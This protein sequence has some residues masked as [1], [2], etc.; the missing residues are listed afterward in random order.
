MASRGEIRE[1]V[2]GPAYYPDGTYANT[3]QKGVDLTVGVRF[4]TPTEVFTPTRTGGYWTTIQPGTGGLWIQVKSLEPVRTDASGQPD[5][6]ELKGRL[7]KNIDLALKKF[8]SQLTHPEAK[9]RWS[10]NGERYKQPLSNP[11]S[12]EVHLELP[13]IESLTPAQQAEIRS[14]ASDVVKSEAVRWEGDLANLPISAR[15]EAPGDAT[16]LRASGIPTGAPVF[17]RPGGATTDASPSEIAAL[18]RVNTIVQAGAEIDPAHGLSKAALAA[19][20]VFTLGEAVYVYWST[21]E[22]YKVLALSD[23][24]LK[25]AANFAFAGGVDAAGVALTGSKGAGLIGAATLSLTSDNP[26]WQESERWRDVIRAAYPDLHDDQAIDRLAKQLRS[27]TESAGSPV[28]LSEHS[29]PRTAEIL[30]GKG[31]VYPEA[32]KKLSRAAA[33]AA[34]ASAQRAAQTAHPSG[35]HSFGNISPGSAQTGNRAAQDAARR[36]QEA[37]RQASNTAAATV[38]QTL[39][40]IFNTLPFTRG[41]PN[42]PV[43]PP[44]TFVQPP[45]AFSMPVF[46]TPP[47]LPP[48]PPPLV[49]FT[50]TQFGPA[51]QPPTPPIPPVIFIPPR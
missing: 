38:R 34:S 17:V 48:A 7:F 31:I 30:G 45:P 51:F 1:G 19:T 28:D 33:A 43:S 27:A 16:A 42:F 8:D 11:D 24:G 4:E 12:A 20:V 25:T 21:P 6:A 23:F 36:A 50:D 37:S 29:R 44:V 35:S 22:G 3:G 15:V 40:T 10:T 39:T 14:Y 49:I 18:A 9:A 13:G 41:T 32:A 47:P 5:L 46:N 26:A 2:V